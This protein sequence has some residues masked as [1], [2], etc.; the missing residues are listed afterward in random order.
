MSNNVHK[1]AQT[2]GHLGGSAPHPNGRGLQNADQK[3]RQNVAHQGGSAPHPNGRGLQNASGST[4][5]NVAS[6]GGQ[7]RGTG[8]KSSSSKK[9]GK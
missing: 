4:K 1:A 5:Q 8:N 7:S 6:K 9:K 3:T 2:L